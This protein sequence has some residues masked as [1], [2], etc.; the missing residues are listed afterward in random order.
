MQA[1]SSICQLAGARR[2]AV[3][4]EGLL[5][6]LHHDTLTGHPQQ[7]LQVGFSSCDSDWARV[8]CCEYSLQQ[9][10]ARFCTIAACAQLPKPLPAL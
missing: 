6:L 9:Y 7:G 4:C 8:E 5:S 1:V 3:V 10:P 2:L